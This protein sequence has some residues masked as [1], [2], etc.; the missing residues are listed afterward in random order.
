VHA[1]LT[2]SDMQ[3]TPLPASLTHPTPNE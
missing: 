3:V 1:G 2:T